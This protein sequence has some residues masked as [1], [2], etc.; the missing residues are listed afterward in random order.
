MLGRIDAIAADIAAFDTQIEQH[1]TPFAEAVAHL[2]EIP[3]IG[4][5]AAAVI[6]VEVGLD[7]TRFPTP[8]H[9]CAWAR[10]APGVSQSAGKNKGRG[11]TG[12]GNRYLARILGEVA[13][14]AGKT[15]TFL[16]ERYWRIAK[17]RG[18]KRAI[19][20]VGR[21]T[22]VIIWHLLNDPD[23]RFHDLGA[24]HYASHTNPDAKKRNHV[25][26]L[27]TLGYTVTLEPAAA[28]A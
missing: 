16:G 23:T 12:H 21:S 8:G 24:D 19:V 13:V 17:R 25:R 9:L 14:T 11:T 28:A 1:L 4:P 18:K 22:L 15:D 20:A 2:D 26:Q 3:G 5:T 27:E 7:M 6:I 10:F